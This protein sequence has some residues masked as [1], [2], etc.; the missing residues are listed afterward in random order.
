MTIYEPVEQAHQQQREVQP[1][2]P[3]RAETLDWEEKSAKTYVRRIVFGIALVTAVVG[4]LVVLYFVFLGNSSVK[5]Q[6]K[7]I[8]LRQTTDL[9]D[10]T[11][12]FLTL[13]A[14]RFSLQ[15]S[16]KYG[17]QDTS[18]HTTNTLEAY[19]YVA[20]TIYDKRMAVAAQPLKAG[21]LEEE[22]SYKMRKIYADKYA[23]RSAVIADGTKAIVMTKRADTPEKEAV[24]FVTKGDLLVTVALVVTGGDDDLGKEIDAI[25]KS[26]QWRS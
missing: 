11:S 20:S 23:E 24:L 21:G 3:V 12:N 7:S 13:K 1:P 8:P 10:R 14:Q 9:R 22:S 4:V 25:A 18:V 19:Q 17:S 16:S 2:P 6:V 26:F 15:Y 5:G